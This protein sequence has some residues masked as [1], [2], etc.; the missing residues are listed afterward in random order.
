MK[1]N[2]NAMI[3]IGLTIF[4]LVA[5]NPA[6]YQ[7]L[8]WARQTFNCISDGGCTSAFGQCMASKYH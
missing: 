7:D 5:A 3:A 4:S 2:V 8:L 6:A 1:I